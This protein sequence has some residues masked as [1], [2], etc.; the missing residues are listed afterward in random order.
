M[1]PEEIKLN[2][3]RQYANIKASEDRLVELR[4]QCTHS[5]T[6]IGNYSFRQAAVYKMKICYFCNEPLEMV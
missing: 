6:F 5:K 3:E 4:K 2:C 1:T